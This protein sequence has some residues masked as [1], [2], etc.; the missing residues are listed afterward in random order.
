M[1]RLVASA[2]GLAVLTVS[3]YGEGVQDELWVLRNGR[4]T[5][6][7]DEHELGQMNLTVENLNPTDGD[8]IVAAIDG[9][10][11]VVAVLDAGSVK[12]AAAGYVGLTDAIRMTTAH[13]E[14][15]V[16]GL[17]LDEPSLG[18]ASDR[19]QAIATVGDDAV[20]ILKD[21]RV[22][23]NPTYGEF[24]I[25]CLSVTV[26]DGLARALGD[27][28][29]AGKSIGQAVVR[30]EA[31][32]DTATAT[33][34]QTPSKAPPDHNLRA[35]DAPNGIVQR[36]GPDMAFCQL[37]DLRQYGHLGS[38]L[39]L[40]IATT[41]WNRGT[42]DLMWFQN[43][44]ERHPF[45]VSNLYRLEDDRFEQIGQSWVKHGFY[46]LSGEQCGTQCTYE[47]GHGQGDW[48]GVGCTDT[49][50][51]SL[52]ASQSGLGPRYEINP[53]TGRYHYP[54]SYLSSSHSHDGQI[55]HRLQVSTTDL[56]PV[57]HPTAQYFLEG[58]YVVAD[59]VE[60]MNNGAWKPVIPVPPASG[61]TWNFTM[62]G[63]GTMANVGFAIDAWSGA[64]QTVI[65]AE[66][67]PKKF[68]SP[69]GRCILAAKAFDLGDNRWRYEYA[70]LNIDMNRKVNSFSIPVNPA[71]DVENIGFH[72]Q[73]N[74]DEP[75]SNVPWTAT[76]ADGA[77][78]WTTED[79]P[80][81]WGTLY[82]FRFEVNA[83][84]VDTDATIGQYET[85]TSD[86][87]SGVTTG[88]AAT[89]PGC[90]A[91]AAPLAEAGGIAKSRFLSLTPSN[92]GEETAIRVTL[93]SLLQAPANIA[94][95]PSFSAFEGQ[96]RWVGPPQVY[97]EH[98]VGGETFVA[99]QLQCEPYFHD[100]GT[101]DLLHVYGPE[102]MPFSSYAVQ[103]VHT[104]C[105]AELDSEASYSAAMQV[106]TGYYGDVVAPFAGE[107]GVD[108]P[109]DFGDISA[110]VDKFLGSLEP[111]TA[112]AQLTPNLVDVEA[113]IDFMDI[114][115]DVGVFLGEPYALDGPAACPGS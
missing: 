58:Y 80:I 38:I 9:V 111:V 98:S 36:D 83:A 13:G 101:I 10:S 11:D 8:G 18:L 15:L 31:V 107:P 37:Y 100:W 22:G 34:G 62:S 2:L 67:P 73:P 49:Y 113:P 103:Q 39:G 63:P 70:L 27:P 71:S 54:G 105:Q 25:P 115:S 35:P 77:I 52:N 43:P 4:V 109:V 97:S 6:H 47:Q 74:D 72:F 85:G 86:T 45:I 44:D 40:A 79:N 88:P 1:R 110:L 7:V 26:S 12:S 90:M 29:L 20:L 55:E 108:N 51:S 17:M 28:S 59:D 66:V 14:V 42:A 75:F 89:P 114:A 96:V 60:N 21:L 69:D 95:E 99:A 64:R 32:I 94:G 102:V 3:A 53:W 41:S 78:T 65:A 68:D 46:A 92:S 76:V 57:T 87:L 48:L 33:R 56:S 5:I 16:V 19:A 91:S 104:T 81:R 24:S 61:S 93:G 30:G 84:P 50:T 23:V 106:D 82:N 112:E